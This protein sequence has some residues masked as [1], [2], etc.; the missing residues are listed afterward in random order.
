MRDVEDCARRDRTGISSGHERVSPALLH[1]PHRH[2]DR[3]IRL[4]VNG[5]CG[6]L[7]HAGDVGRVDDLQQSLDHRL[8][9]G[10]LELDRKLVELS[11]DGRKLTN[12]QDFHVLQLGCRLHRTD[13]DFTG[14]EIATHRI[15]RNPSH[16]SLNVQGSRF[17]VQFQP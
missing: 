16:G 17:K 10:M 15:K 7:V 3:A 11:L 6:L 13:N 2:V 5:L 9:R 14:G 1:K 12:Q 4:A 8:L